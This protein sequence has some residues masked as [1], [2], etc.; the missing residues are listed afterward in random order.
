MR[1]GIAAVIV[2]LLAGTLA[3]LLSAGC[4][5]KTATDKEVTQGNA[6]QPEEETAKR[7]AD[8]QLLYNYF[9]AINDKRY[10][11]A[12][13]MRTAAYRSERGYEEFAASYSDYVNSVK[14]ISVKKLPEFSTADSEEFQVSL[15][16]TYIQ[17][18]PA[19][20]GRIPE[21]YVLVPNPNE[22]GGWLIESEGTGP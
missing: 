15:D 12:Y 2:L 9:E 1:R 10:R 14:A 17:E 7:P 5:E 8:E 21:F 13:D 22:A 16:A 19:G 20:S 18:Y 11:D 6:T 4:D 3:L